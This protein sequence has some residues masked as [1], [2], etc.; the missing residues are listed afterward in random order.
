VST[1]STDSSIFSPGLILQGRYRLDQAVAAGGMAEV[2]QGY[3]MILQRQVAVKLLHPH[4]ANDASLADRFRREAISAARLSHPHIVPTFDAGSDNEV[5]YIVMGLISGPTLAD[6]LKSKRLSQRQT[7]EIGRQIADALDHA[8]K[9]KLIHRDIKPSN[10]LIVDSGSRVMVADFG[11]AKAVAGTS[12]E[13]TLPGLVVGSTGYMAPEQLTGED[14]ID[15][16][17]DVYALG[18]LLHEMLCG[19]TTSNQPTAITSADDATV[20]TTSECPNLPQPLAQVIEKATAPQREDRFDTAGKMRD[21]LVNVELLLQ[22]MESEGVRTQA[23]SP[24]PVRSRISDT[25]QKNITAE[26][27]I[28]APLG[29]RYNPVPAQRAARKRRLILISALL[30]LVLIAVAVGLGVKELTHG[31]Q[32]SKANKQASSVPITIGGATSFDPYSSDH[33]ENEAQADRAVDGNPATTWST[34]TYS[35][36]H[37]GNLKSGVGLILH[38]NDGTKMQQLQI[39]SQSSGWSA[40]VYVANNSPTSIAGWGKQVAGQDGIQPGTTTLQLNGVSGNSVLIWITNLGN[41][42]RVS[43]SEAHI[44]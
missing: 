27:P 17:A 21:E 5:F 25:T 18:V 26:Q 8:H 20:P 16:R 43:I 11:I 29:G 28:A 33:V 4:L 35:N 1:P 22:N 41:D 31:I 19:H 32:T 40:S 42:D 3:D 36:S 2:W 13:A 38:V 9:H 14:D 34:E 15:G 7:A 10:I 30:V 39:D 12:T 24:Q 37:F 6:V 23:N 44:K